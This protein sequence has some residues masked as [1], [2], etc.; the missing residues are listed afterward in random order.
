M[1]M[2]LAQSGSMT[3]MLVWI[4]ILIAVVLIGGIIVFTLR[5]RMLS[6]DDS[7]SVGSSGLLDHLHQLHKSGQMDDEEFARAR[8]AILMQVQEDMDARKSGDDEAS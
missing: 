4:V 2:V 8:S 1:S 6:H 7:V 5:R 3:S